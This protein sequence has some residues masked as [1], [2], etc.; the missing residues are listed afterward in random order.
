ML[1]VKQTDISHVSSDTIKEFEATILEDSNIIVAKSRSRLIRN[2]IELLHR[3]FR[4]VNLSAMHNTKANYL[5]NPVADAKHLFVIMM[6]LDEKKYLPYSF[7]NHCRSIYLFD[8]WPYSYNGIVQF[9][10]E[11]KIDFVFV[12]AS[13]SS[14]GLNKLLGKHNVFW[15]P[16]GI[17]IGEYSSTD[18]SEKSIDVL[19][20]GR[21][22][23]NYH[24]MIKDELE[25][26]GFKYL[27]EKN[28]DEIVFEKRE[29][30]IQG[31]ANTKIS[32]CF[33]SNLTH[34]NRAGNIETMTI[35]YLQSM[36]SKCL[37]IGHAPQ[38]MIELFG[39]NPVI[40]V[41]YEHPAQ[42]LVDILTKYESYIP[43]IE[44]NY[45]FISKSQTWHHRW[46]K[47]KSIWNS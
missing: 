33:P 47:M 35:R 12:S 13:Q 37:V 31:L 38:E 16:E 36:A 30:Y 29:A 4:R 17:N 20:F 15:I 26:K 9:V 8:A 14:V 43:M 34:P 41:D 18:Y 11:N 45:H 24:H 21:K 44:K 25:A 40:E 1:L 42:Q 6:G 2:V 28:K 7:T 32:I 10:K 23:D 19:A 27:Y 3:V 5:K 39:Y 22:Y 46:E